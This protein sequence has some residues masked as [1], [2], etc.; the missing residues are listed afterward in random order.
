MQASVRTAISLCLSIPM[1]AMAVMPTAAMADE[2]REI[3]AEFINTDNQV[4]G[5][6]RLRQGQNATV[7]QI[8]LQ[9]LPGQAGP[10]AIHIHEHGTCE[11][12]DAGFQASGDHLNPE[13][14]AHGLLHPDGP[15]AGD[16]PNF[17]V[18][19]QGYAWAEFSTQRASLDG[20]LGANML[21]DD[22]T[23]LVI[24]E[25]PDDHGSQPIGGAGD[26]IACAVI[27]EQ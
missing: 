17:H 21:E 7:I 24:H 27:Q 8:E 20:S 26:R 2:L 12:Y 22:G 25:N 6:A 5:S 19:D 16:L 23:A 18:D 1:A 4:V 11:D 15:D 3:E 13:G 10:R 14:R 9:D